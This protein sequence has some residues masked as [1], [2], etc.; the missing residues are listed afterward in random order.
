L[1]KIVLLYLNTNNCVDHAHATDPAE[2]C[3]SDAGRAT[4][5]DA[6]AMLQSWHALHLGARVLLMSQARDSRRDLSVCS[7]VRHLR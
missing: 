5:G 1:Y 7:G 2:R 6:E 4:V 3:L